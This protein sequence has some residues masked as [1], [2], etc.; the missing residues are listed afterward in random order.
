MHC[1]RRARGIVPVVAD[2]AACREDVVAAAQ[3]LGE[4]A[5]IAAYDAC[6]EPVMRA[7]LWRYAVVYL[8]G[9]IYAD[10]DV[11]PRDALPALLAARDAVEPRATAVLF[12]E[13]WSFI[14][15]LVGRLAVTLRLT[16]FA[17]FPQYRNCFFIADRGHPA[18]AAVLREA[19][20]R[21]LSAAGDVAEDKRVLQLTGPG[22][23]TDAIDAYRAAY[24]A[25]A[26][27]VYLVDRG[28]GMT[29]FLHR[30][31]GSWKAGAAKTAYTETILVV[32]AVA[33]CALVTVRGAC[34]RGQA[35]ARRREE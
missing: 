7:D 20:R 14:P 32:A 21:V 5:L 27:S 4:E 25:E 12:I 22:V 33:A 16:D 26:S 35:T 13:N 2:D 6:A 3:R 8:R 11:E 9:G 28:A 23:F 1:R 34:R 30:G 17:T 18:L 10:D 31:T 29:V 19:S 24:P 15:T